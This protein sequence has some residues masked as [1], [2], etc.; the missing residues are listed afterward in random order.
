MREAAI[1]SRW[2]RSTASLD[3][4]ISGLSTFTATGLCM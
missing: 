3:L 2:K 4:L 1:A